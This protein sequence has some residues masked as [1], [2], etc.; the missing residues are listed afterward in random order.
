MMK[1]N[2]KNILGLAALGMTLLAN[3]VPTWAGQVLI[4]EVNGPVCDTSYCAASGS[5]VGARYSADRKQV[6]G[7]QLF[8]RRNES[9]IITCYA[10]NSSGK[11]A[12]CSSTDPELVDQTQRMTDSSF[13][14]FEAQRS[15]AACRNIQILNSSE[16]LQ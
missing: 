2:L 12:V 16:H 5:L 14:F 9:P 13:I 11:S 10:R 1:I 15:T 4:D 8:A 3:T 6:I 7:C